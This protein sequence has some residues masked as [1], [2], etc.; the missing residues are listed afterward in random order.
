MKKSFALLSLA[1]MF[2]GALALEA[3]GAVQ[4]KFSHAGPITSTW[5]AGAEKF[6]ELVKAGTGGKFDIAIFPLDE[7]SG[8]SQ[9]GGIELVQTGVTDIHLQDALVWSA[10]AKKSVVPCFPWLLPTYEDVDK[11]MKGEGGAALK[12]VLNEADV[13]CL[14]IGE[15]GYRQVVNNRNP[16]AKPEDMQG[17]K[18]RVPGSS[19]HVSLLKYIGADPLT[20]N[21]SEVYTSL[22]QGTIDACE[23]T[24]DLLYTQ[25]TLEVVKY[26]SL[27]NYSYDPLYLSVSRE[28]WD[29]LSDEEKAVFQSA[30]DEAMAY[31][32]QITREKNQALQAQLGEYKLDIVPELT[33]EQVRAFQKA[34][35]PV[36]QDYKE[37]FGEELFNKFGY[38]F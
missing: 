37:E 31:Q 36:Y 10:V 25:K 30:A 27:W 17:L 9:V 38:T 20:M 23:N 34:V 8:G 3:A 11:C 5:Q 16:I 6:V 21:Q 35:A 15:N 13:V 22:Q 7:L 28:L 12:A 29:S 33:L 1:V 19:V 4:L 14:A 2:T 26:L 18:M 32:V 24:L